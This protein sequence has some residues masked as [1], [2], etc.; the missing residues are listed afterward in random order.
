[1]TDQ[2]GRGDA[3]LGTPDPRVGVIIPAGGTAHRL[4]GIDKPALAVGG[5]TIL[6]RLVAD[7]QP[8]PVAVVGPRPDGAEWPGVVWCREDPPG[9]GPAAAVAAGLARLEGCD[10]VVAIAGDQP[11]AASAVPRLL[12]ALALDPTA[13][14][15]LGVDGESRDQPLLAAYRADPLR[16]R[17]SG[18]VDG[19]PMRHLTT[20]LR[21]VRV[22]LS[23]PEALDVDDAADLAEARRIAPTT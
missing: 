3:A 2:P 8:L 15:A 17:L 23:A 21:I 22:P 1:V 13:E 19:L 4:A 16:A 6:E 5:R 12:R 10:V 18:P 9:G 7:L 11:F 14:V 20:G